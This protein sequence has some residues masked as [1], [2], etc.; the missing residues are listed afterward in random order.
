M[1][2][3]SM[4]DMDEDALECDLMETY[5]IADYRK[6]PMYRAAMYAAGLRENSRIKMKLAGMEHS[7]DRMLIAG[8]FDKLSLLFWAKTE[9]GVNG[10]NKPPS[11]IQNL[12]GEHKQESLGYESP[13]EFLKEWKEG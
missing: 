10:R 3:A 7:L 8:C 12:M 11:V 9:D 2:L 4:V 6:L 13:E 1:L 5:G